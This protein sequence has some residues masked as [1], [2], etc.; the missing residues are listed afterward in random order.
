MGWWKT[1]TLAGWV[2]C[3]GLFFVT[4]GG[5]LSAVQQAAAAAVILT[6]VVIPYCMARA[7]DAQRA[8]T[9]PPAPAPSRERST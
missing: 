7:A 9:D 2:G 1:T 4:F 3:V 5:F 6:S 8:M